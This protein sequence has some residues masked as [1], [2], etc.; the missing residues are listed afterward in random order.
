MEKGTLRNKRLMHNICK[1]KLKSK[2][3]IGCD[4]K[5]AGIH[6]HPY[7]CETHYA[8]KSAENKRFSNCVICNTKVPTTYKLKNFTCSSEC[9]ETNKR[10]SNRL[11]EILLAEASPLSNSRKLKIAKRDNYKC[12][13]CGG[14]IDM[15]ADKKRSPLSLHIDHKIPVKNDGSI[16][17]EDLNS[18]ENLVASHRHCNISKGNRSEPK[19]KPK[20]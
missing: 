6:P 2:S 19:T 13:H 18:D 17:I 12:F 9:W 10:N 11:R 3:N 20:L 5:S 8:E 4:N 14:A 7:L 16:F 15:K 1:G